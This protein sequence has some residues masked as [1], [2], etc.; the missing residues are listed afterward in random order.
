M[1]E[2]QPDTPPILTHKDAA[3]VRLPDRI[4]ETVDKSRRFTME[5]VAQAMSTRIVLLSHISFESKT[6]VTTDIELL[7]KARDLQR[8]NPKCLFVSSRQ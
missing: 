5:Q 1:L 6:T 2:T 7:L 3:L 4:F 8:T